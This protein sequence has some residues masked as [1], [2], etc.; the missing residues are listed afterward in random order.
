[1]RGRSVGRSLTRARVRPSSKAVDLRT[2][3]PVAIKKLLETFK[4]GGGHRGSIPPRGTE[5]PAHFFSQTNTH[6]LRAYREIKLLRFMNHENVIGLRDLFR[7]VNPATMECEVY[8][9]TELLHSDLHSVTRDQRLSDDHIQFLVYQILRAL[10]V[11]RGPGVV[12][13]CSLLT[14]PWARTY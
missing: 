7:S 9:V 1:M 6:A 4:V 14:A 13:P 12:P 10:K 11:R 2:G 5:S 3:T 8:L